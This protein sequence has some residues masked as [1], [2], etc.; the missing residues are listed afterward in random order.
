MNDLRIDESLRDCDLST[1]PAPEEPTTTDSK[2]SATPRWLHRTIILVG[3]IVVA[4]I[5]SVILLATT[6]EKVFSNGGSRS[7]ALDVTEPSP[8]ASPSRYELLR[9][10]IKKLLVL[11]GGLLGHS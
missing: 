4:L 9:W 2:K 1:I 10:C 8:S 7:S 11:Y 5:V 3:F 6:V